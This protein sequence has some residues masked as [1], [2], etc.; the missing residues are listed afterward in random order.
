MNNTDFALIITVVQ[1]GFADTVMEAARSAG[2]KGGTT[3]HARGT[4][5]AETQKFLGLSIEPEKDLVMIL[6]DKE[7]KSGIMK[8]INEKAGLD[9]EGN[10]LVFA[11]PVDDVLFS[12]NA[13]L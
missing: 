1:K 9:K 5:T 11:V 13:D 10:G 2:A 6:A 4:S 12:N 3:I 7:R 8:A